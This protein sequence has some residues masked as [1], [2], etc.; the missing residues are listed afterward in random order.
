M[1]NERTTRL[2]TGLNR[3]TNRCYLSL[4]LALAFFISLSAFAAEPK[5]LKYIP[6]KPGSDLTAYEQERCKLD[7]Y[8]PAKPGFP[9]LVWF[10]GGALKTGDAD[11][12]FTQKIARS[13]VDAEIGFVIVHY[14]YSPK[15]TY[16]AY[17]QDAAASFAWTVTNIAKHGGNPEKVFLG[18]HSAGGYLAAIVGLDAKRL[19]EFGLPLESVAGIIPVSG[20]MMTHY[21]I[22]EERGLEKYN[23]IA[24]E[25]APIYHVRKVTPP[26]LVLY[27]DKDMATREEENV[28]FVSTMKA[29]GNKRVQGVLVKDRDHGSIA[30]NIANAEDPAR[31]AI[32]NFITEAS[33]EREK[34][35]AAK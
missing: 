33:L 4:C 1:K 30:R 2:I 31:L 28:Y 22:R 5:V 32:V 18:G 29:A 26:M 25:A 34:S 19:K 20:Q 3:S 14:R 10:H 27:A 16:P 13:L 23:V 8:L 9:T 24:D 6:Y 15:V 12:E 7:L 21:T 17:L 35:K 11:M